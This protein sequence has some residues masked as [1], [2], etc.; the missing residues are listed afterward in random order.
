M[1]LVGRLVKLRC[2]WL[3]PSFEMS[4]IWPVQS[5]EGIWFCFCITWHSWWR[6]CLVPLRGGRTQVQLPLNKESGGA[7]MKMTTQNGHIACKMT[8]FSWI[9]CNIARCFW[10]HFGGWLATPK[11]MS[12]WLH[13]RIPTICLCLQF[14][15]GWDVSIR[16]VFGYTSALR[17]SICIWCWPISCHSRFSHWGHLFSAYAD[18]LSRRTLI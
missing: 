12:F 10:L 6:R 16:P 7:S 13:Q 3:S 15:I 8:W 1:Q 11:V 9:G 4:L 2:L 14:S 5:G 18:C 17:W